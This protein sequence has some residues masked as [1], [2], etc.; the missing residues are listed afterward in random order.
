[1][2]HICVTEVWMSSFF[3]YSLS[4][5][6]WDFQM[7]K[8]FRRDCFIS[9]RNRIE[10]ITYILNTFT[11]TIIQTNYFM[12]MHDFLRFFCC[13]VDCYW[14]WNNVTLSKGRIWSSWMRFCTSIN[15]TERQ[16]VTLTTTK[17]TM[18]K[19]WISMILFI[20][21]SLFLKTANVTLFI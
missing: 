7:S 5:N 21:L 17:L 8:Y 19:V 12:K 10:N 1:M 9:C 20:T 14:V 4:L 6:T 15:S 11:K 2:R 16:F 3:H 13:C 18:P